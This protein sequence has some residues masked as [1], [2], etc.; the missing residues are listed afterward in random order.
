MALPILGA[1]LAGVFTT[2]L[3]VFFTKK[4]TSIL[5][6]L[7]VSFAVFVGLESLLNFAISKIQ[8]SVGAVGSIG[9]G[10][11]VI[12]VFGLLGA[13]GVWSAVNIILSGHAAL[14]TLKAARI[15]FVKQS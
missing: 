6:G 8:A 15:A 5:F 7:G 3:T 12:D 13:A 2:A 14:L 9:F 11:S 1:T 10:G 4:I